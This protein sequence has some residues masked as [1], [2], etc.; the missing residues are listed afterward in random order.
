[1]SQMQKQKT[2]ANPARFSQ[3]FRKGFGKERKSKPM[4]HSSVIIVVA[5]VVTFVA[6]V[7]SI[8]QNSKWSN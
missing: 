1:M 5:L 8:G 3:F 6:L 7:I 4:H 2:S